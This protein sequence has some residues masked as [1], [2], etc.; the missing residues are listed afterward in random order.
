MKLKPY[1]GPHAGHLYHV[2]D[3][4]GL[5]IRNAS[6]LEVKLWDRLSTLI[7]ALKALPAATTMRDARQ[8]SFH[9]QFHHAIAKAKVSL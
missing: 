3:D 9:S 6:V 8:I 1:T 2:V 7:E 5:V 4:Q